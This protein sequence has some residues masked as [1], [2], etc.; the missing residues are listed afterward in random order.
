[1][2]CFTPKMRLLNILTVWKQ[3]SPEMI[4]KYIW[5]LWLL[6]FTPGKASPPPPPPDVAHGELMTKL[7]LLLDGKS[8]PEQGAYV[9]Q[10]LNRGRE[11]PYG[12][13]Y[14]RPMEE[15]NISNSSPMSTLTGQFSTPSTFPVLFHQDWIS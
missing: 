15:K 8:S 7:G 13:L 12:S 1:M 4:L 2:M 5:L 6:L 11:E 3:F 9:A 10:M 14:S